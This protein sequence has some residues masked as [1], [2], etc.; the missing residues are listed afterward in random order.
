MPQPIDFP[1]EVAKISVAE[2]IQQITDRASLAAQQRLAAQELENQNR[3]ETRIHE[4]TQT[5][6]REIDADGRRRPPFSGRRLRRKADSDG[7]G[8]SDAQ[9]AKSP[10]VDGLGGRFD[11]TI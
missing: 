2:R 5:E 8:P 11:V 9:T 4:P 6:N 10:D 7:D 1:S 3:A